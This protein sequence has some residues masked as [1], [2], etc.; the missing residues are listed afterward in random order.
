LGAIERLG[1][2]SN[3]AA[4][5]VCSEEQKQTTDAF[6]F[7]WSRRESYE[8]EAVKTFSREWLLE[9]YC[10]KDSA[11]LDR[12]LSGERRTILDAGW[13]VLAFVEIQILNY[14]VV[15]LSE[16]SRETTL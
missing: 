11:I 3:A 7:K 15:P 6:S 8:S 13:V 1:L 9:R 5:R 2:T 16:K 12:W 10:D 4:G 14:T